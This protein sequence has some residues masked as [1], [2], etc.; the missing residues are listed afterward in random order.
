MADYYLIEETQLK[1][2]ESVQRELFKTTTL[3][4]D[5]KRDIANAIFNITEDIRKNPAE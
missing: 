3:N 2:F 5:L 1:Y 4:P